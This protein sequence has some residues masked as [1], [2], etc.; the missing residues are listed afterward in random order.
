MSK[1]V[2]LSDVHIGVGA[3][4]NWFQTDIHTPMLL[5]ILEHVEREA[6]RVAEFVILGD[7]VDQWTYVPSARPP[8][9]EAIREANPVLFGAGVGGG[10]FGSLSKALGERMTYVPGN[11]DLLL[12]E[13]GVRTLLG[14]DA[15]FNAELLYEPGLGKSRVLCTHGHLFSVFNAPDPKGPS[16]LPL[17]HIVTRLAALWDS[18]NLKPGQSVANLPD[19]GSPTGWRFDKNELETLIVDVVQGD[20]SLAELVVDGLLKATGQT[21][22]LP[23]TLLDGSTLTAGQAIDLYRDSFSRFSDPRQF[24]AATY[25]NEPA[26]FA[27]W[28][29]D[30]NDKLGHFAGI[31]GEKHRV[32]IMGHTHDPSEQLGTRLFTPEFAYANSGFGCPSLPD[33][34]RPQQ[35]KHVTFVELELDASPGGKEQWRLDVRYV[36]RSASGFEVAEAPLASEVINF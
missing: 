1:L 8:A 22:E 2:F 12:G 23:I 19:T 32:V 30:M 27:L 15:R 25:G 33:L 6:D 20:A 26:F 3:P 10:A 7:L 29:C 13:T 9:P 4:T 34:A 24:P 14:T 11:H 21:R 17:G 5:A 18:Q 28:D 35:P 16:N 36:T 31:L